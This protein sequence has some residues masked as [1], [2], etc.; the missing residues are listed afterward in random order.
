[1]K[2]K[3]PPHSPPIP[4]SPQFPILLRS[5]LP[6]LYD[7]SHPTLSAHPPL[8]QK[9]SDRPPPPFLPPLPRTTNPLSTRHHPSPRYF[10]STPHP[11]NN[12]HDCVD[13]PPHAPG[14]GDGRRLVLIY[15][16]SLGIYALASMPFP[17]FHR[18][19]GTLS[20]PCSQRRK[21][22]RTPPD[23]AARSCAGELGDYRR[24][25]TCICES[26]C[27]VEWKVADSA[28]RSR[29]CSLSHA[30]FPHP[31]AA[32][33]RISHPHHTH[34]QIHHTPC[35]VR[36]DVARRSASRCSWRARS[37]KGPILIFV[38]A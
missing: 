6:P 5:T 24:L 35:P 16:F 28:T 17:P 4:L 8:S 36:P 13:P 10:T 33:Q 3:S 12:K 25:Q 15:A 19:Q 32:N 18:G 21:Q 37:S 11:R 9:Y 38:Y 14:K 34:T 29:P 2:W 27:E 23:P 26:E 7:T 1:M 22:T 20:A 31:T 30:G